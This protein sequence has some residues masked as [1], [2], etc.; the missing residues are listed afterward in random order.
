MK[1]NL[2]LLVMSN[3][4]LYH[5]HIW[6]TVDLTVPEY[7]RNTTSSPMISIETDNGPGSSAGLDPKIFALIIV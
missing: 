2:H 6:R 4:C 3:L 5:P 1:F 7:C